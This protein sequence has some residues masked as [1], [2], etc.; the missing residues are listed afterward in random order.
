MELEATASLDL[1]DP[2]VGTTGEA[3]FDALASG[4][5]AALGRAGGDLV[6]HLRHDTDVGVT[7]DTGS[8]DGLA[9]EAEAGGGLAF[10]FEAGHER[11][12]QEL[13]AA[14]HRPPGGSWREA[15]CA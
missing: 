11:R 10:G 1:T 14:W 8:A 7:L 2:E 3:V 12:E 5:T 4:D 6:D 13:A 9:V 15:V